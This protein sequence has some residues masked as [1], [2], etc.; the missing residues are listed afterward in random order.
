MNIYVRFDVSNTNIS[1][2]FGIN[3]VKR[4][5]IKYDCQLSIYFRYCLIIAV[6]MCST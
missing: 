6:H 3:K 1:Y 2:A 4:E 5:Q